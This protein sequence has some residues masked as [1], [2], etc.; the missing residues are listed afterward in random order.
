M[1]AS[2]ASDFSASV[3]VASASLA[4]STSTSAA[5]GKEVKK[6]RSVLTGTKLAASIQVECLVVICVIIT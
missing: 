4:A 6:T 5:A 3:S 2:N 1:S